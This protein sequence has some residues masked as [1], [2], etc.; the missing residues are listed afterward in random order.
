V[1]HRSCDRGGVRRQQGG[2]IL[3]FPKAASAAAAA[4]SAAVASCLA[5]SG[6][7]ISVEYLDSKIR[8]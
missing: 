7:G 2:V 5:N 3:F 6:F 4:A 8:V 1:S